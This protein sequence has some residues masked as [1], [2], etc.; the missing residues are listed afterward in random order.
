[1]KKF[2]VLFVMSLLLCNVSGVSYAFTL[3]E[4]V[5]GVKKYVTALGKS[6]KVRKTICDTEGKLVKNPTEMNAGHDSVRYTQ[7]ETDYAVDFRPAGDLLWFAT[8]NPAFKLP[9]GSGA[10][11]PIENVLKIALV[12]GDYSIGTQD[13]M[14]THIWLRDGIITAISESDGKIAQIIFYD[15]Q[16]RKNVTLNP[17]YDG[18][19][20][21]GA[22]EKAKSAEAIEYTP[23]PADSELNNSTDA[24]VINSYPL[25]QKDKNTLGIQHRGTWKL[26]SQKKY[27]DAY[28]G[29]TKLAKDYDC[30]YLSAYW[31]GETALELKNNDGARTWFK[32]ALEINPNYRPATDALDR[33]DGKK[34]GKNKKGDSYSGKKLVR[35]TVNDENVKIRTTPGSKGKVIEDTGTSIYIAEAQTIQ[36]KGDK[37]KWYKILFAFNEYDETISQ[38]NKLP[39]WGSSYVYVNAKSAQE[40]PLTEADIR[41][42]DYLGKGRPPMLKVGDKFSS[43]PFSATD[44]T[45]KSKTQDGLVAVPLR[46]AY[47][48]FSEPKKSAK[49]IQIPKGTKILAYEAEYGTDDFYYHT[50]ADE[51][52]WAPVADENYKIIGWV[53]SGHKDINGKELKF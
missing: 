1:M 26:Y 6:A 46:D 30:N 45:I 32:R 22:P 53:N 28:A 13:N 33:M 10:G 24:K 39:H 5:D 17:D 23:L 27:K 42:L 14:K 49:G 4:H 19:L 43:P 48:L 21:P 18:F 16:R 3:Q 35:I 7:S 52:S 36:D 51:V 15:V 31:A 29:F 12:P 9:D 37:S 40:E 34:A 47:T 38:V 20:V 41:E 2:L 25:P 11:D 8:R 44:P 50:D